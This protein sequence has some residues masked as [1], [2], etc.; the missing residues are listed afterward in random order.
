[1]KTKLFALTILF[2]VASAITP[3]TSNAQLF[4]K[5]AKKLTGKDSNA[6]EVKQEEKKPLYAAPYAEDFSDEEGISGAYFTMDGIMVGSLQQKIYK[7]KFEKE[8]ND[9]IVNELTIYYSA[10]ANHITAK[11]LE[12]KTRVAGVNMFYSSDY[13]YIFSDYKGGYIVELDEGVYGFYDKALKKVIDVTA[14]DS[15]S[16]ETY[17]KEVAQAK[18][19]QILKKIKEDELKKTRAKLLKYEAYKQNV[20]KLRFVKYYGDVNYRSIDKPNED[21]KV[22]L[23]SHVMG[24]YLY[25]LSY[26][27]MPAT[28]VCGEDCYYNFVFEMNGVVV[29]RMKQRKVSSAWSK[30]IPKKEVKEEFV[31]SAYT[32][33]DPRGRDYSFFYCLYQNKDK[34]K[35]GNDYKLNMKIYANRDGENKELLSEGSI[36]LKYTEESEKVLKGS[37]G[38][39]MQLEEFLENQ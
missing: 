11:L 22:F 28:V 37:D 9:D 16:F 8:K 2:A 10:K 5:L 4:K 24:K 19:E 39:F 26:Y 14:K 18:I 13:Y 23:S 30:K 12:K 35:V 6:K 7:F 32:L 36:N 15:S 31:S 29:E 34:F 25:H 1:M 21:P 33:Y 20:G 17:D 38:L 3:Q 27:D